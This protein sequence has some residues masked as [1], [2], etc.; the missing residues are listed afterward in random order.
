MLSPS[1]GDQARDRASQEVAKAEQLAQEKKDVAEKALKTAQSVTDRRAATEREIENEK[2]LLVNARKQVDI[3]TQ[4]RE[5]RE[6]E[7]HRIGDEGGLEEIQAARAK[8]EQSSADVIRAQQEVAGHM[9]ASRN[10]RSS[11]H[12]SRRKNSARFQLRRNASSNRSGPRRRW[13]IS[14]TPSPCT[15]SSSGCS[16]TV[17]V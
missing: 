17:R 12:R 1:G 3:A 13:S 8:F 16:I 4:T 15:T 7:Y 11:S 2:K 14:R 6:K 10:C 9:D 5:L